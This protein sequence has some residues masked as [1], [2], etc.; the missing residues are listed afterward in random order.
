MRPDQQKLN[1]QHKEGMKK[2]AKDI[3]NRRQPQAASK[4]GYHEQASG[5]GLV[6]RHDGDHDGRGR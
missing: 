3:E 6:Q 5:Q 2:D 1:A 4:Q